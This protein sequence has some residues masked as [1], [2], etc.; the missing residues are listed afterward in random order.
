[1]DGL[2]TGTKS[3]YEMYIKKLISWRGSPTPISL[4]E[5]LSFL[6][7]LFDEGKSYSSIAT[8][9]SALSQFASFADLTRGS[10][11]EHFMVRKFMKGVFKKRP[12]KPKYETVWDVK[13][14]LD[15]LK[16]INI[17]DC[18]LL[19]LSTKL[20]CLIALSTGQRLQTMAVL[21]LNNIIRDTNKISFPITSIT[22]TSA[23][24]KS[25]TVHIHRYPIDDSLCP[26]LT[27]YKYLERTKDLR[28]S[29][30][31]FIGAN[32]PHKP[33]TNQTLGRWIKAGLG[34]ANCDAGFGAHS[35]RHASSST[36]A[37]QGVPVNKILST[38]GWTNASTFQK[39]YRRETTSNDNGLTF[40]QAV[41][42]QE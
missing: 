11:A 25:F 9:K 23:P 15:V 5:G 7:S 8:A 22:K 1:M 17:H 3:Q 33:V 35:T 38:V 40:C 16:S 10:F 42:G 28:V 27:T 24:G 29:S 26:L 12:G 32:K 30:K 4:G 6:K 37:K 21:D 13:P 14:L 34:K 31:L 39:F 18:S 41:L 20:A 36:A 2:A 19:E